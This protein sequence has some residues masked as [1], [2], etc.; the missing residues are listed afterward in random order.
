MP[1]STTTAGFG[2]SQGTART[3]FEFAVIVAALVGVLL[4]G[5]S[6]VGCVAERAALGLPASLDARVGEAAASAVRAS[7]GD[8]APPQAAVVRVERLFGELVQHLTP[9]ERAMLGVPRVAV[10]VDETPNAFALPGGQVFVQSGLLERVGGGVDGDAQLS[11]VLAHEL[12]HAIRRH[13]LRLLA[14]RMAFGLAI[15]LMMGNGDQL[16]DALLAG[17]SELEGLRNSREMETDADEFGVGLL[18][19]AGFDA[20]GLAAFLE[21]LGSQ[22][23]PALLSTHPDPAARAERIRAAAAH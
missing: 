1:R 17:A 9:E 14:R 3:A 20:S 19:R 2:A 8:E 5:R 10:V 13:A 21:S 4:I 11:G 7:H 12:G 16:G 15:S 6:V 23:V 18:R 22:P